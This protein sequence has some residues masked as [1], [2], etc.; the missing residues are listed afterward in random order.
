[1]AQKKNIPSAFLSYAR[2]DDEPFVTRLNDDLRDAGFDVWFDRV[3]LP[4]RQLTFHQEIKDA[5]RGRD[6]LVY[7]AGPC[8]ALSDYVREEWQFALELDKPII[9]ILRKGDYDIVPGVLSLLHCEDFGDDSHYDS[10]LS[11]LIKDLHRP[12]PPLGRLFAVPS[13]PAHFVGR[14]ELMQRIKDALLID[15]QHP[16]VITGESSRV[17]LQGMG[18]IGKSILA[19]ALARDREIRRSY[20]DGIIWVLVGQ[21]P[22]SKE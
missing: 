11:K 8:A 17:G 18:G 12:E 22:N 7:V 20:P 21:N 1:M 2:G 3:S 6:K 9:P 15:L 19:I 5:I 10:H 13:L 16:V 14:P 4:S